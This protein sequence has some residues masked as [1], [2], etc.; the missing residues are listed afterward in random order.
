MK[1]ISIILLTTA[2]ITVGISCKKGWLDNVNVDPN[3]ATNVAPELVLS[4][5]LV[6]SSEG[7][8][9]EY[10]FLDEWMGYWVPSGS[11]AVS[12]TDLSTYRQTTSF[13]DG[14]WVKYYRN[15]EDYDYIEHNVT[16]NAFDIAAA[17]IMKAYMFQQLVDM[18]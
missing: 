4:N 17:N 12:A 1:K 18:R 3:N 5:A 14:L 9:T 8:I 10:T 15:M 2:L 13:G 7:Q 11:Y 16:S 6:V